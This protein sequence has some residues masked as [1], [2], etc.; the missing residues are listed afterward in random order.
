MCLLP[1]IRKPEGHGGMFHSYRLPY[2]RS[3]Y[4]RSPEIEYCLMLKLKPFDYPTGVYTP[5]K[6]KSRKTV[7]TL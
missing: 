5:M 3:I 6:C 7:I 2:L 1:E 4:R